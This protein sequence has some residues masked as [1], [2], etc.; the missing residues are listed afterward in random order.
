MLRRRTCAIAAAIWSLLVSAGSAQLVNE[1]LVI[2]FPEGFKVGNEQ[3]ADGVRLSEMIPK[4]ETIDDW[5]QMVT[6]QIFFGKPPMTP[7]E[8]ETTIDMGWKSSCPTASNGHVTNG[9]ENGYG[10]SLWI[11]SCERNPTTGKP[12]T[13]LFKAIEGND[14]FYLVQ[15]AFRTK[16]TVDEIGAATAYLRKIQVCDSRKPEQACPRF[17]G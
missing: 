9:V 14:S 12:E 3:R 2:A 5:T 15:K 6:V 17:G 4:N 13:T 7:A 8:F 10:F 16:P 11:E 1:N